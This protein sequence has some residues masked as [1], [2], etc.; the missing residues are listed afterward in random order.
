M[1]LKLIYLFMKIRVY[2]ALFYSILLYRQSKTLINKYWS[3]LDIQCE[4]TIASCSFM[5]THRIYHPY[6]HNH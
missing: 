4:I 1:Y 2:L 6:I 5:C 3:C